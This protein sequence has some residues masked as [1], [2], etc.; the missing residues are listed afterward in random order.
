MILLP[1]LVY[2]KVRMVPAAAH[3]LEWGEGVGRGGSRPLDQPLG[4]PQHPFL[5]LE[6]KRSHGKQSPGASFVFSLLKSVF[7]TVPELQLLHSS[8]VAAVC[9]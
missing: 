6:G 1:E 3:G 8:Q 5:L 2:H 7:L 9:A 4:Q